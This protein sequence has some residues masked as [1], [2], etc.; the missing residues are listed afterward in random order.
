MN[1]FKIGE[2]VIFIVLGE[3]MLG[4]IIDSVKFENSER[5]YFINEY[6]IDE[7][8]IRKVIK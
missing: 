8:N 3:R 4:T 1:K 7:N 5:T 6:F 2:E